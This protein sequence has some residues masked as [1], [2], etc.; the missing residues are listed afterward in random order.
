M[1]I[2]LKDIEECVSIAQ[3]SSTDP[4]DVESTYRMIG[5][6][7]APWLLKRVRGLEDLV[8]RIEDDPSF[9]LLRET[10]KK[11]TRSELKKLEN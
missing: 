7:Y 5:E 11:R 10:V 4:A 1:G 9:P 2:V 6:M 8:A 3:N